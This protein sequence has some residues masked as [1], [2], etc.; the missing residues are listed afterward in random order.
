[1]TRDGSA[2]Y[3]AFAAADKGA[4]RSQPA[5]PFSACAATHPSAAT[6]SKV[7][8]RFVADPKYL[9]ISST[10]AAHAACKPLEAA[11]RKLSLT[12]IEYTRLRSRA[13]AQ[14]K[15]AAHRD[16]IT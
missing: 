5:E 7:I 11:A 6:A 1:T 4:Y 8:A 13:S 14:H 2:A 12:V 9:V 15:P 16:A 3:C 10:F